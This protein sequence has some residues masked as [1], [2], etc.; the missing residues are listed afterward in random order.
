MKRQCNLIMSCRVGRDRPQLSTGRAHRPLPHTRDNSHLSIPPSVASYRCFLT[1]DGGAVEAQRW[2][3]V[4]FP[5]DVED[6]LVVSLARLRLWEVLGGQRD[7][8]CHP[9][10]YVDLGGGKDLRAVLQHKHT[11]SHTNSVTA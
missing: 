5:L 11:K 7:G 9:D 1:L 6:A 3:V 2:H 4:G 8:L 10:R